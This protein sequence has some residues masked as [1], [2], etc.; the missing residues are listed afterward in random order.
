MK[1]LYLLF[2]LMICMSTVT[3]S[4]SANAQMMQGV[5]ATHAPVI[6]TGSGPGG[7]SGTNLA[8]W[9]RS[10]DLTCTG[11]CTGTNVVTALVDKSGN[12][13]NCTTSGSPTYVATAVN[14]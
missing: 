10:D 5:V 9:Y 4:K 13:N 6:L 11:G 1:K 14:S 12:A 3:C 7:I 8:V 2:L